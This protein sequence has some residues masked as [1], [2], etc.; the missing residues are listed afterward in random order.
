MSLYDDLP[1]VEP[2][3][4]QDQNE[5]SGDTAAGHHNKDLGNSG[6]KP[7]AT[8]GS[9]VVGRSCVFPELVPNLRRRHKPAK[10]HIAKAPGASALAPPTS[11]KHPHSLLQNPD[12]LISKWE[13]AKA[14]DARPVELASTSSAATRQQPAFQSLAAYFPVT[15]HKPAKARHGG[16]SSGPDLL[17]EYNPAL[18]NDYQEYKI[19]AANAKQERLQKQKQL[20]G[21]RDSSSEVDEEKG[22]G[23]ARRDPGQPSVRIVLT[24]MADSIDE[25]LEKETMEECKTFG[26]VVRCTAAIAKQAAQF[27][28]VRVVVEFE[29]LDAAIRAQEALDRRFFDGRHISAT[30]DD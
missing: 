28:R 15:P 24:N 6:Q 21:H 19:W 27:E 5:N 9:S 7:E 8:P 20:V 14:A 2:K 26:C 13:A 1:P 18:P 16:N 17:S 23:L 12:L 30:F 10:T 22:D 3:K 4:G 25:D 11:L 29:E